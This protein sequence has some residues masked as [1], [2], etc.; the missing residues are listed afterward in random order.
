MTTTKITCYYEALGTI[1]SQAE[2]NPNL[3]RFKNRYS[4]KIGMIKSLGKDE[5]IRLANSLQY[6][7]SNHQMD[8]E[9]LSTNRFDDS[10]ID[11]IRADGWNAFRN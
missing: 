8:R 10:H 2:T 4:I 11:G 7:K 9:E 3:A 6:E 1:I 5:V